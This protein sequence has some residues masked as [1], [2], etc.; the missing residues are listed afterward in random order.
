MVI[1]VPAIRD[2]KQQ[3][4]FTNA[5]FSEQNASFGY[6]DLTAKKKPPPNGSGFRSSTER[7]KEHHD[8]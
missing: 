6:T 8:N 1:P 2:H 5:I 7:D 4:A 3:T